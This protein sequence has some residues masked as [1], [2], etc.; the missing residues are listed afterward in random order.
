MTQKIIIAFS[1]TNDPFSWLLRATTFCRFSHTSLVIGEDVYEARLLSGVNKIPY[2]E[3][4]NRVNKVKEYEIPVS[5]SQLLRIKEFS[6]R[7]LGKPYD[8][9]GIVSFPFVNRNWQEDT[10]WF[11]SEY[12][13]SSLMVSGVLEVEQE[14]DGIDPRDLLLIVSNLYN[15][16]EIK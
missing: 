4:V 5:S 13:V 16:T 2:S 8:I 9:L 7:Q 15:A 11:C 10:K 14:A 12:T 6:E 3:F 1:T